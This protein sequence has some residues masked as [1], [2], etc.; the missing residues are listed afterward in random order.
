MRSIFFAI[1]QVKSQSQRL[2]QSQPLG[3]SHDLGQSQTY[4]PMLKLDL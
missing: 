2:G 3:Q 4:P 1:G